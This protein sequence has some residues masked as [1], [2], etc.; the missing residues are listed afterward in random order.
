MKKWKTAGLAVFLCVSALSGCV[1]A[2]E[3]GRTVE[4]YSYEEE[5][6]EYVL[7]NENLKLVLD[8]ATTYFT[9]TDKK[10]GKVWRSNP[11]NAAE[12][13]AADGENKNLLQSTLTV[14]Y[15]SAD[16]VSAVLNNFTYSIT[17]KR[18]EIAEGDDSL[19]VSYQIG[20]VKKTFVIPPA[21][22]EARMEEYLA[23]MSS[24]AQK[25][26]KEY[27]RKYD[28][29]KLRASDNKDELLKKYPELADGCVYALRDGLQDYLKKKLEDIFAE[30]GYTQV[31]L[32]AD[33][34]RYLEQDAKEEP[35][36]DVS[37]VYRL[38]GEELVAE[39]PFEKLAWNKTYPMTKLTVLPYMGAGSAEEEG[40]LLVPEGP[41]GIIRFNNGKTRQNAYY[42]DVYGWD[43][44]TKREAVI[45]ESRVAY[46]V[47]AVA[48][49]DA[50][51]LCVMEDGA[52]FATVEADV[53]GRSHSY[54]F[55]HAAYRIIHGES[56]DVSAKSDKSVV[57]FENGLPEG[58]IR[59]CYHFLDTGDY[60]GLA[61]VYRDYLTGRYRQLDRKTEGAPV[62]VTAVGAIDKVRQRFG[63]PMSV[64]VELTG[65]DELQAMMADMKSRGYGDLYL[66][67]T[68]WMNGGITHSL[69]AKI[70][71]ISEL[72]GKSGL[73]AAANYAKEQGIRLYL[74]GAVQN[75]YDSGAKDGFRINRDSARF[76]SREV[77]E[78]PEYSFVW[79]GSKDT[80][81]THYRLK[82][83]KS[84]ELMDSLAA[85]A[86]EYG[87][88]VAYRD[89]G[90]LLAADYNARNH[91]SRQ[92]AA[93]MECEKLAQ[94]T[95]TGMSVMLNY[96][97]DYAL[98]YADAIT[99]MDLLGKEYA[100][101]DSF[102]PFYP[103]A[104]HGLV[105]YAGGSVN[106]SGDYS[107]MVLKSAEMGASLSFTFMMEPASTLQESSYTGYYGADYSLWAEKAAELVN[108]YQTEMAPCFGQTMTGHEILADGVTVTRYEDGTC[109]YVNYNNEEYSGDGI[110]IPARDYL[111][112]GR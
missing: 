46:P 47:F 90:Y 99:D 35:V 11:E 2:E 94:Q 24:S 77:A 34:A 73:T 103:M 39:V 1:P 62:I 61:A 96:G 98:A 111:V 45:D 7:E 57:V 79:Y 72:G 110:A 23:K 69:P 17:D 106:L 87:A 5:K 37:V 42:A 112:K 108:R 50:S 74:E 107:Q 92:Q 36:F 93:A 100:V 83:Q 10:N 85:A 15:Q 48:R 56:L 58:S 80:V 102:V 75:A 82:P 53:S 91:V 3:L 29:N 13:P 41:G 21:M 31:E 104:V 26:V 67:M 76:A 8:P 101:I 55:V 51:M 4:G 78:I 9:V 86:A 25:Q 89:V 71:P 95:E 19:T 63:V 105:D 54:N 38:E 6:Q 27:Y 18:Y 22:A 49:G 66:K 28:L 84:L 59:Q 68:G 81:D 70:K 60:S 30:A 40:Y 16:G 14:E 109:V 32:E 43:M 52:A 12:D 20:N 88:G 65:F 33:N 97:N 64:D 44:A